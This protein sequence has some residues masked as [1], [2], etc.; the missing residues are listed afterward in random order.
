MNTIF[1]GYHSS[2]IDIAPSSSK[3][4]APNVSASP[5]FGANILPETIQG[6]KRVSLA[7]T[8]TSGV[9]GVSN[10]IPSTMMTL[11]KAGRFPGAPEL[12]KRAPDIANN[13]TGSLG[14][15]SGG[16]ATFA[17]IVFAVVRKIITSTP[18]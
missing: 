13:V 14:W 18:V 6:L 10:L 5:H 1:S 15:Y 8:I 17:G 11:Y 7:T 2:G 4:I 16:L 3:K 12:I 9:V